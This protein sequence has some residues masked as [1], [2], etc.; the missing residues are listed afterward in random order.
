MSVVVVVY[1]RDVLVVVVVVVMW[2]DIG[3]SSPAV[4]EVDQLSAVT[5]V[6]VLGLLRRRQQLRLQ[7]RVLSR[8]S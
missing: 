7:R 3:S 1:G 2:W 6:E 5:V 4:A 8:A